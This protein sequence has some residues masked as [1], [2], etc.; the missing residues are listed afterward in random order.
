MTT[1]G[2]NAA[3]SAGSSL[4]GIRNDPY[5]AFNFLVEIEGLLVGGF[6]EVSGL[7]VEVE[8]MS[9]R[10]GGLNDYVH[11]LAG[12]TNYPTNLVLKHGLIEI[13]TLWRWH[14]A[15]RRGTIER[16]N[17]T[18]Y[19]LDQ[20]RLPVMWWNFVEAYPVKWT[21]PTFQAA[22]NT[23]AIESVEL[24]HR[25]IVKPAESSALAIARRMT[26]GIG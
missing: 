13:D 24:V 6:S 26:G 25:G 22:S 11:K 9:Y 2:I 10:E 12:A 8:V 17:G 20:Q 23:V 1:L 5:L 15:V 3:F 18:I 21:G 4:L 16:K 19:L 7:Q 14:E